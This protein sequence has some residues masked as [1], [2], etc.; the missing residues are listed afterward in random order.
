MNTSRNI[1]TLFLVAVVLSAMYSYQAG[2]QVLPDVTG[3]LSWGHY[4]ETEHAALVWTPTKLHKVRDTALPFA[5]EVTEDAGG[6][7]V[8]HVMGVAWEPWRDWAVT[9]CALIWTRNHVYR[10]LNNSYTAEEVTENPGGAAISTVRGIVWQNWLLDVVWIGPWALIWTDT[11]LLSYNPIE[12]ATEVLTQPG[13]DPIVGVRGVVWE[14]WDSPV[15]GPGPTALIWTDTQLFS[16]TVVNGIFEVMVNPGGASIAEVQGIAWEFW[17]PPLV[18]LGSTA[19]IWTPDNVYAFLRSFPTD[20]SEVLD[21]A[22]GTIAGTEGIVWQDYDPAQT[23]KAL[24]WTSGGAMFPGRLLAYTHNTPNVASEVLEGGFFI[25]GIQ[26]I[27]WEP[28]EGSVGNPF[29]NATEALI[30]TNNRLLY[31]N[32]HLNTA[33]EV[34]EGD[35]PISGVRGVAWEP[36]AAGVGTMTEALVWTSDRVLSHV[37][38]FTSEVLMDG[39][40]IEGVRG[41]AWEYWDGSQ[42]VGD[43]PEALIWTPDQVFHHTSNRVADGEVH[44]DMV[45]APIGDVQGI[46]WEAYDDGNMHRALIWKSTKILY[47]PFPGFTAQEIL[48][49]EAS[50]YSYDPALVDLEQVAVHQAG[51]HEF[52]GLQAGLR[53]SQ[54]GA[55]T[56]NVYAYTP[57]TFTG[58]ATGA[59]YVSDI[60]IT[61]EHNTV[62][63]GAPHFNT[64]M[65]LGPTPVASAVSGDA[66]FL[67]G[68]GNFAST[69]EDL[70]K[71]AER[72]ASLDQNY[73]NPFNPA[74]TITYSLPVA[75]RVDLKIH[76]VSGRLI[77]V[78]REGVHESAGSH[79][80][81]WDGRDALGREV[82]SG[83]YF[84]R[85][86]IDGWVETKRMIVVR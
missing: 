42:L 66:M 61:S 9:P 22:G 65:I 19:L 21:G 46:V 71:P 84:Y 78:L 54:S 56:E 72:V 57:V 36:Y 10:N 63:G 53:T 81:Q 82:A 3:G 58:S 47:Y 38:T 17:D 26:G 16:Y 8:A 69:N 13:G 34:L 77:R 24:I 68:F 4:S 7:P 32:S 29:P 59:T 79:K 80:I 1:S 2:A 76:D 73:P 11:Q 41:I 37:I 45:F 49:N 50:I 31:H 6:H 35:A 75:G 44:E 14:E 67:F 30:W 25:S 20:A 85:L 70:E 40:S 74:T 55:G 60:G 18:N 28:W 12:G 39:N 64:T 23:S 48:V 83:T 51:Y 62:L 27:S 43:T 86:S 15:A 5:Q 52:D 33:T